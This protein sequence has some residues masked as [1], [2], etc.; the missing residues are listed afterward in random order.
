[1]DVCRYALS[2]KGCLFFSLH[3][4]LS[5]QKLPS[6]LKFSF[7]KWGRWFS[8]NRQLPPTWRPECNPWN[9]H[10]GGEKKPPQIPWHPQCTLACGL[11]QVSKQTQTK[12]FLSENITFLD[13]CCVSSLLRSLYYFLK[14]FVYTNVSKLSIVSFLQFYGNLGVWYSLS[15]YFLWGEIRV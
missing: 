13:F 12:N 15:C 8:G 14:I 6:L 1:M 2:L 4:F 9:P 5:S 7:I 3:L 11:T 10:C